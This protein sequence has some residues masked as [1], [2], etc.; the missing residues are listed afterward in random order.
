MK[1]RPAIGAHAVVHLPDGK[2]MVGEVDGGSGH[3][4]KRAPDLHFGLG[5]LKA[6]TPLKV[7]LRWRGTDGVVRSQTI[8]VSPGWHTVLLGEA[9]QPETRP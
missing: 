4:G 6:P 8:T 2:S 5:D 1:S 3:S 7:D 9:A